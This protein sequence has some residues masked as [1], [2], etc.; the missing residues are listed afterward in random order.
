MLSFTQTADLNYETEDFLY[1]NKKKVIF[2]FTV[3]R[4]DSY[5]D[6]ILI[7]YIS[8]HGYIQVG[9]LLLIIYCIIKI[10]VLNSAF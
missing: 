3:R 7:R 1:I 8:Y 2:R 4:F 10:Y 9:F 5:I 6:R